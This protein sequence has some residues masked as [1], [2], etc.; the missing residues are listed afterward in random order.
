MIKER[1]KVGVSDIVEVF[2]VRLSAY[3]FHS[4]EAVE[5][6]GAKDDFFLTLAC[7]NER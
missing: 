4:G 1:R 6:H 5:L 3:I 2:K 7:G